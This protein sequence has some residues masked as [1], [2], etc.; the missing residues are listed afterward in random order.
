MTRPAKHSAVCRMPAGL[1]AQLL[2]DEGFQ[3]VS[4]LRALGSECRCIQPEQA[5]GKA[6][7]TQVEFVGLHHSA[8]LVA[9]PGRKSFQQED[10]LQ[11]GDVVSNRGAAELKGGCQVAQVEELSVLSTP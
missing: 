10:V 1:A 11:Q 8:G 7:V 5:A 2:I 6:G 4:K 9:V 3:H